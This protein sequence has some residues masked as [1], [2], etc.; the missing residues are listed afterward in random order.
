MIQ[1]TIFET[2]GGES[3]T[4]EIND[5]LK[6]C[7]E[8]HVIDIKYNCF[9]DPTNDNNDFWYTAL[10][11]YEDPLQKANDPSEKK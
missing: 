9:A 1:T 4:D 6:E 10:M 8:V 11:I 3:L 2:V 7:P 5:F